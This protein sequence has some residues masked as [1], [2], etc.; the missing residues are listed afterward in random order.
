M[1]GLKQDVLVENPHTGEKINYSSLQGP[2]R[3]I[4]IGMS[5][6]EVAKFLFDNE[7]HTFKSNRN[8]LRTQNY[9]TINK[10]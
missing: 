8:R 4:E 6:E 1:S 2:P 3:E 10:K 7:E 5:E 9:I